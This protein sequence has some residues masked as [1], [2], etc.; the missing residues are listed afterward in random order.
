MTSYRKMRRIQDSITEPHMR[1]VFKKNEETGVVKKE[2]IAKSLTRF[3]NPERKKIYER[4]R[5]V[6][7]ID[8]NEVKPALDEQVLQDVMK[9]NLI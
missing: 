9:G 5:T 6:I 7:K 3:Q 2:K 8:N 1:T 4:L